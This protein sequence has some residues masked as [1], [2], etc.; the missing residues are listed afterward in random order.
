MIET[1][2]FS[3]VLNIAMFLVAYRNKTDKLTDISYALTFIGIALFGV[4][5]NEMSKAQ[6]L[7]FALVLIWAIRLGAYLLIRIRTIK[8]D[9]RFDKMRGN[10]WKF[11]QFWIL[12]AITAW[13]VMLP[14]TFLLRTNVKTELSL[15]VIVSGLIA[16]SGI[17]FE[18]FADV[19]KFKFIQNKNNAGKWIDKG[20]W[21]YSRHP[22]YFGE[23]ITWYGIYFVSYTWL[24]ERES[25]MALLGPIFITFMLGFVSG[26]PMLEAAADKK[27]GNNPKYKEYKRKTSV[28]I[29]L[30]KR[31]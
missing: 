1:L 21:R 24:T 9:K 14:A 28:L 3:L 26:L 2:I 12:Q 27:W 30:P 20:L 5:N 11:G 15:L 4:F 7:V 22:N 31:K 17:I 8:R 13:I 16:L 6:W 18:A 19:Q 23:I 25:A 29:P 10:F